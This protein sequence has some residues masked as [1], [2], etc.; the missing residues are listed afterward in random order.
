MTAHS[1][2]SNLLVLLNRD[3]ELTES[4]KDFLQEIF[5]SFRVTRQ[6][7][8]RPYQNPLYSVEVGPETSTEP[9]Q[10]VSVSM[11]RS[12]KGRLVTSSLGGVFLA[13]LADHGHPLSKAIKLDEDFPLLFVIQG[14][15]NTQNPQE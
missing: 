12:R 7:H 2:S 10:P 8:K 1:S 4:T 14:Q 9:F 5:S 6:V 11:I 15:T 13:L 3:Q